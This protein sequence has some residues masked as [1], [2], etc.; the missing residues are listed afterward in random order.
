M[1]LTR[2]WASGD[3]QRQVRESSVPQGANSLDSRAAP[4]SC[5][6]AA[7]KS[8]GHLCKVPQ[9]YLYL[10]Q[11]FAQV[12]IYDSATGLNL[13]TTS[14]TASATTSVAATTVASTSAQSTSVASTSLT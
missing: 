9:S 1:S 5:L 11:S 8:A 3:P 10:D 6:R 7:T 4:R 13:L 14:L 2:H 12:D